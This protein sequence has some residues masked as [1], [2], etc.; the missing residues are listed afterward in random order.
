MRPIRLLVLVFSA[1]A[2]AV[3][4]SGTVYGQTRHATLIEVDDVINAP[5]EGYIKRAFANA[6]TEDA[7]LVIV[8]LDTPG[9]ELDATR[10]I[11]ITNQVITSAYE[12]INYFKSMFNKW[13]SILHV[14]D[15]SG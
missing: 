3:G 15:L 12:D 7:E 1:L 4:F 6:E 11:V 8:R 5:M 13:E 14:Y 2:L 9:G 10:E